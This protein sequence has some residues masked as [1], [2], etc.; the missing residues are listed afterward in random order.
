MSQRYRLTPEGM[1]RIEVLDA[2]QTGIFRWFVPPH[3]SCPGEPEREM[4]VIQIKIGPRQ[5][6]VARYFDAPERTAQHWNLATS[7]RDA[8]AMLKSLASGTKDM[9]PKGR[10]G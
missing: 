9:W 4:G 1:E 10:R 2:E 6:L 8:D 3:E 5:Y 7:K